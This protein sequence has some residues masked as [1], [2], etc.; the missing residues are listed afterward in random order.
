MKYSLSSRGLKDLEKASHFYKELYGNH[1]AK[2]I[3]I[4]LFDFL[5]ILVSKND[6]TKIGSQDDQFS[7]HKLNYRKVFYKY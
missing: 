2:G 1:K 3:I 6:F 4:G 7:T 5:D